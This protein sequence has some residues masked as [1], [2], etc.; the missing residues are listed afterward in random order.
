MFRKVVIE[1]CLS[2]AAQ[3]T[4]S[5][6]IVAFVSH[7]LFSSYDS[8]DSLD[9]MAP[10]AFLAPSQFQ[11]QFQNATALLSGVCQSRDVRVSHSQTVYRIIRNR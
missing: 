5:F 4:A 3:T 9:S 1:T 2:T 10:L 8:P 11:S 7:G 6:D